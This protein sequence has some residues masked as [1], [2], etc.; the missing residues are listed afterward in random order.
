MAV[1]N[2]QLMRSLN[3]QPWAWRSVL[4]GSCTLVIR[5]WGKQIQ[6]RTWPQ[7]SIGGACNLDSS[8]G[9]TLTVSTPRGLPSGAMVQG[10]S[11]CTADQM[12]TSLIVNSRASGA[13]ATSAPLSRKGTL[14]LQP[15]S[16]VRGVKLCPWKEMRI[17]MIEIE[18][19]PAI[20]KKPIEIHRIASS[21]NICFAFTDDICTHCN[22][23]RSVSLAGC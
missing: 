6:E 12:P 23:C 11:P 20:M 1:F 15:L 19:R 8:W 22:V 14:R 4:A 9:C 2:N 5:C 18:I 13:A 3:S 21:E 7:D 17:E 16:P 10:D